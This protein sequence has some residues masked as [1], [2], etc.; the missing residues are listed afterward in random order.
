[1]SN[2]CFILKNKVDINIGDLQI[3]QGN[4]IVDTGLTDIRNLKVN[5]TSEF[6][7]VAT[8]NAGIV[9]GNTFLDQW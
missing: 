3:H 8:F 7:G 5:T 2:I 4:L 1:M 6:D 9:L